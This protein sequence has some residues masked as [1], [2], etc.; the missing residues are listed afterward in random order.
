MGLADWW[1]SWIIEDRP[2]PPEILSE[3]EATERVRDYEEPFEIL[4]ER[5]VE[6]ES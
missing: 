1:R 2:V 3:A 4:L 5:R 6:G